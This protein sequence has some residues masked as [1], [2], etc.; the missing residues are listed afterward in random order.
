V[1][2]LRTEGGRVSQAVLRDRL[3]LIERTL[4]RSLARLQGRGRVRSTCCGA[5]RNYGDG[6]ESGVSADYELVERRLRRREVT[7]VAA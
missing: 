1:A 7:H 6:T 3:G 4:L 2:I 5:A